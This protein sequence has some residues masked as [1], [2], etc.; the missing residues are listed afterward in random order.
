[1]LV[2]INSRGSGGGAAP[3]NYLLGENLDRAGAR[4][5][6]GNPY[7]TKELIDATDY[8]RRYTSGTLSFEEAPDCLTEQQ[9]MAVIEKFESTLFSGLESDQFNILWVEH[10]DKDRLELNFLIPNQELRSGKRLQPYYHV[11]DKRRVNAFQDIINHDYKLTDPHDP[12]KKR[13]HNPYNGRDWNVTPKPSPFNPK[14]L[15]KIDNK[16]ELRDEIGKR[17]AEVIADDANYAREHRR[18]NTRHSVVKWL[19]EEGLTVTRAAKRTQ[20][21]S[22]T[23]ESITGNVRLKGAM[24]EHNFYID[25]Y[26]ERLEK[27]RFLDVSADN[28]RYTK[29]VAE[30]E[31]GIRIK[32]EYHAD[33]FTTPAPSP[34]AEPQQAQV[35]DNEVKQTATATRVFRL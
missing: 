32:Q 27:N 3:V 4:V 14:P 28:D 33:R 17:L 23:S 2:K 24:Y 30:L 13:L 20:T 26:R 29:A 8:A 6:S 18:I 1:M 22:I 31:E 19:E 16:N 7:L 5:L 25:N 35:V 21:I 10:T 34:V 9:K 15:A 12:T 11:A